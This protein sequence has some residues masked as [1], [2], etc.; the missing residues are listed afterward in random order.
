M[1]RVFILR[2]SAANNVL[3]R[4]KAGTTIAPELAVIDFRTIKGSEVKAMGFNR[5]FVIA[6]I[7][8]VLFGIGRA[9]IGQEVAPVTSDVIV[10]QQVDIPTRDTL[11]GP[12][13]AGF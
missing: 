13:K 2:P 8:L 9:V 10:W 3:Q 1:V 11:I 12:A 6:V 4:T 7:L 5:N